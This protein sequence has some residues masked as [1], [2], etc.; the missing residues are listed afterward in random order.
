MSFQNVKTTYLLSSK[1]DNSFSEEFRMAGFQ[2]ALSWMAKP[3][4]VK[5]LQPGSF[6]GYGK[7]YR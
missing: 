2:P 6:V 5:T 1:K 4:M 3:S 7:T